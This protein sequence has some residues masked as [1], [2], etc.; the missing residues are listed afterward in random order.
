MLN[1]DGR[2]SMRSR[3][4]FIT[5]HPSNFVARVLPA[6]DRIGRQAWSVSSPGII[7]FRPTSKMDGNYGLYAP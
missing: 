2:M 5:R 6:P 3:P 1:A 7:P 4:F